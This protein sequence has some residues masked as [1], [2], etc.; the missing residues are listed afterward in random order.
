MTL[1]LPNTTKSSVTIASNEYVTSQTINRPFTRLL[2]N[3]T[4]IL[5]V[6]NNI[7]NTV[8]NNANTIHLNISNEFY[9]LNEKTQ[10][11]IN[12]LLIIEDS[13]DSGN[14]KKV[15]ASAFGSLISSVTGS[16][17]GT[18]ATIYSGKTGL[19]MKF[20]T[21]IAGDGVTITQNAN[22]ITI[23]AS[24]SSSGAGDVI[25][26]VLNSDS[27]IPQWNGVN[28]KTL[29]NGIPL[30]TDG[31]LISNSDSIIPTQKAIKTY[32]DSPK[33]HDIEITD[34]AY[35]LILKSPNNTRW[36]LT[37]SDDGNPIFTS[38]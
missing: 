33:D 27:Y 5:N 14:K 15:K 21:I 12:D 23:S 34:S 10:P 13:L 1:I 38:L 31:S 16:N 26:P 30:S 28:T 2:E 25:G 29:K 9:S 11:S 6:L 35:G 19:T 36:R 37:V 7:N 18:G 22:N 3:D 17:I 24:S 32:V 20:K 8:V 4:Y